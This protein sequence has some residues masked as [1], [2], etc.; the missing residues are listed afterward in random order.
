MKMTIVLRWCVTSDWSF[1][2]V[3]P[4]SQV[5][6]D[7]FY[8]LTHK[9]SSNWVTWRT[10]DERYAGIEDSGRF[11]LEGQSSGCLDSVVDTL[12]DDGLLPLASLQIT[13]AKLPVRA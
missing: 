3:E 4:Q 11:V 8:K 10:Q 6:V 5:G 9:L 12:F 7:L 13:R 1:W 2:S